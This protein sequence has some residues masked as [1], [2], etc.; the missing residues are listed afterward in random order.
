[1]VMSRSAGCF[2]FC[3]IFEADSI[4]F[5]FIRVNLIVNVSELCP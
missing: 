2:Y 3:E 5:M 4:I 1:M